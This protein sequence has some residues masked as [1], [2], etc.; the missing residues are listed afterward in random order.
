MK[1]NSRALE[2][3]EVPDRDLISCWQCSLKSKPQRAQTQVSVKVSD[4]NPSVWDW[5]S[6]P[7]MLPIAE[8]REQYIHAMQSGWKLGRKEAELK[9]LGQLVAAQK[10]QHLCHE[11]LTAAQESCS[12][13]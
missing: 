3:F 6:L 2:G 8:T 7:A 1:T 11:G 13:S 10:I 5:I 4:D 9:L 12:L